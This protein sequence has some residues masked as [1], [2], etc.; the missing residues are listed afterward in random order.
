MADGF[1]FFNA[2]ADFGAVDARHSRQPRVKPEALR[3]PRLALVRQAREHEEARLFAKLVEARPAAGLRHEVRTYDEIVIDAAAV[4]QACRVN[5][6][7]FRVIFQ[8]EV[9][10]LDFREA[11]ARQA[12]H[13]QAL[14]RRSKYF[15]EGV[16][17][18]RLEPHFAVAQFEHLLRYNQMPVVRGVE[19]AA[20]NRDFH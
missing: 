20:E 16:R 1:A 6:V 12:R 11:R 4:E 13:F 8:F 9:A 3:Q 2:L 15:L 7:A 19:R 17:R 10:R 5:R 18:A 14:R